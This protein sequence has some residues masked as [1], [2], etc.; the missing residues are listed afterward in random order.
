VCHERSNI[1]IIEIGTP[2]IA[3][4]SEISR[5]GGGVTITKKKRTKSTGASVIY[6]YFCRIFSNNFEVV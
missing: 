1:Y 3:N 5:I 4:G 6:Q 2:L